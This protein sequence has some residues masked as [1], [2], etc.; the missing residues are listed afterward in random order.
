M[1]LGQL[2]G[3]VQPPGWPPPGREHDHTDRHRSGPRPPSH[4]VESRPPARSPRRPGPVRG[5]RGGACLPA[6]DRGR[7]GHVPPRPA[8][9]PGPASVGAASSSTAHPSD[10]VR[11]GAASTRRPGPIELMTRSG[12]A[13]PCPW[14][15]GAAPPPPAPASV[16]CS[17]PAA[18]RRTRPA[19]RGRRDAVGHDPRG[20]HLA[21]LVG[22]GAGHGHLGHP[23]MAGD[24]VLHLAGVHVEPPGD[25]QLLRPSPDDEIPVRLDPEVTGAEPGRPALPVRLEGLGVGR[26]SLP[27]PVEHIRAPHQDLALG[28]RAPPPPRAAGIRPC[29]ADAPPRTGW[30]RSSASRSCRNARGPTSRWPR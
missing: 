15:S 11:T 23:R 13:R 1:L 22:R 9:G 25:D 18:G 24:H 27:V 12:C 5:G 28:A 3:V 14:R 16:A 30:T 17:R 29:R 4:L 10:R 2:L 8:R 26:R 21:P 19:R 6:A 20:D 7:W